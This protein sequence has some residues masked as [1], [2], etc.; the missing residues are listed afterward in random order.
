MFSAN[1]ATQR[2]LYYVTSPISFPN[3]E[4]MS[5]PLSCNL[6]SPFSISTHKQGFR[7]QLCQILDIHVNHVSTTI[8][9]LDDCSK[10]IKKLEAC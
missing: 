1:I 3:F 4:K 5:C 7:E 10:E 8:S 9:I 2:K 6:S